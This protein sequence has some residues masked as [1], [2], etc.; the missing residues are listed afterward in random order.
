MNLPF[1]PREWQRQMAIRIAELAL[2]RPNFRTLVVASCGSGKTRAFYLVGAGLGRRFLFLV[3]L[4]T[5]ADQV[6]REV[7]ELFPKMRV[8][9]CK[10]ERHDVEAEFL[11]GSIQT[12]K[13]P[14]RLA[15]IVESD[16]RSPFAL[17]GCDEAHH[18]GPGST[19]QKVLD[20][21]PDRPAIGLTATPCRRDGADLALVWRDGISFRYPILDAQRDGVNVPVVDGRGG[22]PNKAHRLVIPGIDVKAAIA[23]D[24]QGDRE[25]ARRAIGDV[26]WPTVGRE[27]A[28]CTQELGRK[29]IV[30][31][32][33][34]ESAH[35]V[36]E[37]AT[38]LG[39]PAAAVDGKMSKRE[40]RRRL[41][42]H[43]AGRLR[44]A[45][46]CAIL[47]EGYDDRSVDCVVW[48]RQTL[49]EGLYVQS[50]GRGLRASP[51]TGKRDCV[52]V[53]MVGAHDVHGL[54]TSETM[55]LDTGTPDAPEAE[56]AAALATPLGTTEAK[57]D[58][59]EDR[60]TVLWRSFLACLSGSRVLASPT[61]DKRRGWLE[62][63]EN[64]SYA[65][66]SADKSTYAIEN[67]N[68][69]W[70]ALRE[71]YRRRGEPKAP[72]VRLCR[73]CSRE[74]AQAIAETAANAGASYDARDA[75]WRTQDASKDQLDK[76][77]QFRI[78][79]HGRLTM[80]EASDLMTIAGYRS[81]RWTR[82]ERGVVGGAA[83]AFE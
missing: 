61:G 42:D 78:P 71:P 13:D 5:L 14:D 4:D 57:P 18:A 30:F 20:A 44:A 83:E 55:F 50:V 22:P 82:R 33:D 34:V 79:V 1:P 45:V 12:L 68:G 7:R 43:K 73:P 63:K 37:H 54:I 32:P 64:E 80:G 24:R 47:C 17:I 67:V 70:V 8:G 66:G 35:L 19:Y 65:F 53:D 74:E 27:I 28:Y 81:K 75:E 39:V 36:A 11:I 56:I 62:V 31:V 2:T 16:A 25:A 3:H 51:E 41:A 60:R 46:S 49:S 52:I 23:A 77:A 6:E 58:E 26:A 76:L 10:A 59:Q 21:M 40:V 38:K 29:A 9:C 69:A 72:A 48:A 15:S